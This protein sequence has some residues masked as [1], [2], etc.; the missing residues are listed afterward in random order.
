M[1]IQILFKCSYL[2]PKMLIIIY[3][4]KIQEFISIYHRLS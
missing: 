2:R 3:K 4:K 1:T